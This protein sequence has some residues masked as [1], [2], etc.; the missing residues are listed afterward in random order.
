MPSIEFRGKHQQF[1]NDATSEIDAEGALSSGKTTVALWKELEW[2]KRCPGIS[3]MIARWVEKQCDLILRPAFEQVARVHGSGD[4]KWNNSLRYYEWPNGSRAYA[5]GLKTVSPDP[6]QRYGNIRGWAGSRI[7]VNQAEQLPPDYATELRA[8]LRPDLEANIADTNYPRQLTFDANS[9]N[10]G[11]WLA[12][13]FPETQKFKNRRLYQFSLFDNRHNLPDDQVE[14]LLA[15]WPEEHPKHRTQILGVRGPNI[16]GDPIFENIFDRHKH[17]HPVEYDGKLALLE[18]F[19]F[20]KHNPVVIFAQRSR[21]G[22]V[23]FL[24][25]VMGKHKMLEEFLP[26][27]QQYR[28]EWFPDCLNSLT[29]SSIRES[30]GASSFSLLSALRKAGYSPRWRE[31]GRTHKTQLAMI[32]ET[33]EMLLRSISAKEEYITVNADKSKWIVA[34]QDGIHAQRPFLAYALDGG[35]V[36]S[37]Q[38]VSQGNEEIRQP[39]QDDEYANIM[40]AVES[41]ILNFCAGQPTQHDRDVTKRRERTMYTDD[42]PFGEIGPASWMAL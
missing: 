17:V 8:R 36:W 26:I 10:D 28:A 21:N 13:Q 15:A 41:L 23:T 11:H 38:E 35:Y 19:D 5:Y 4:W 39:H 2:L 18:S 42:N 33:A 25:G 40:R 3:I 30:P 27:V 6:D 29:C 20:G 22:G 7:Y 34:Q 37:P 31:D 12:Q 1:L 16:I 9:V 14:N 24:G 32:E